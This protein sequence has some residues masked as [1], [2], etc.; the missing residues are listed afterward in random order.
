MSGHTGPA[1]TGGYVPPAE[2]DHAM[3]LGT[4]ISRTVPA[5]P[6]GCG[7][8]IPWNDA[9][10]SGRMLR[11]HLSQEHDWASRRQALVGRHIACI[12]RFLESAS[13]V[14]DLGCGPGLYT[15]ALAQLGHDCVGVDFSPA[16]IAHAQETARRD[17]LSVQYTLADIRDYIPEGRFDL[18][19][20]LFGE[21]NVFRKSDAQDLL[22]KAA[23]ALAPGG[24]LLLEF[25]PF[26]AIAEQGRQPATWEALSSGL[27][28]PA[29]H[30]CLQEHFWDEASA[31]ATTRY[32]IVEATGRVT[33][34]GSSSKAYRES[35]LGDMLETCGF[36]SISKIDEADWPPGEFFAGKLNTYRAICTGGTP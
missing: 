36:G 18:V 33:E 23:G 24:T 21:F 9:A 15:K 13:R 26:E 14:L 34:Y 16:S 27:F 20:M 22:A 35:E 5:A 4:I 32:L 8:K 19:M 2:D 1:N 17:K 10:F 6:W 31:T 28:C 3:D 29:P 30:L 7:E 11:Y 12:D 25:S